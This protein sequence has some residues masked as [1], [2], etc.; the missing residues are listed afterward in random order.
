MGMIGHLKGEVID[1]EEKSLILS[2]NGVG[3]KI[4]ATTEAIESSIIGRESSFWT[5]HVIREEASDLFG[6]PNKEDLSL[7]ELLI[8]ISGI[9][10]RT[11]LGILSVTT[12]STLKKAVSSGDTSH[13]IKVSGIGKKNA[14]K[15][16]LE[17]KGKFDSE[18][19]RYSALSEEVDALDALKA[20]GFDHKTAREALKQ[21]TDSSSTEDK[22]KKALKLLGR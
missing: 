18:E 14:E 17:L 22:I 19:E 9:G 7:F 3:Y 8:S 15:I 12:A 4:Y 13:L 21:V 1:K 16:V 20:L 10:P 2:I 6:F 5:H 11:A